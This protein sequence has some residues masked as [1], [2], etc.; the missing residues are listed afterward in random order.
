MTKCHND[1]VLKAT[2]ER[3][4]HFQDGDDTLSTP[5]LLPCLH[6]VCESG[7]DGKRTACCVGATLA[8]TANTCLS[9]QAFRSSNCLQVRKAVT[10]T[11]RVYYYCYCDVYIEQ[12]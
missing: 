5:D 3:E 7:R 9:F 1:Q 4:R 2:T 12:R 6:P 10:I 8:L 11:K